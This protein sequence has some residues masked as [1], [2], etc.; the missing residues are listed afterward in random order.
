MRL[1][2][3][4]AALLTTALLAASPT[5]FGAGTDEPPPT[6]RPA[7]KPAPKPD[8]KPDTKEAPKALPAA[9]DPDYL[10]GKSAVAAEDWKR[11]IELLSRAAARDAGNANIQNYLGFANR[12]DG[13]W[14]TAMRHYRV[15]LHIDPAHR[16]ATEYMGHAYLMR[17]NLPLARAQLTRLERLCGRS[18][19]EYA[20]LSRA[21]EDHRRNPR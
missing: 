2:T 3:L 15:A 5:G 8:P 20:S 21:I 1:S 7:P 13:N 9:A 11:A 14:E 17:G 4:I 6:P 16:G 19:D 12:N 18:C 10:A